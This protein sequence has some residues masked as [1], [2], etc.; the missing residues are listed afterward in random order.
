MREFRSLRMAGGPRRRAAHSPSQSRR[1][2][3]RRRTRSSGRA[4]GGIRRA[5][6]R[7]AAVG[8]A[9][10]GRSS[11]GEGDGRW[12]SA[13]KAH[14]AHATTHGARARG[15][16]PT[17]ASRRPARAAS[18]FSREKEDWSCDS[19]TVKGS[20][21][22]SNSSNIRQH[23]TP[24]SSSRRRRSTPPWRPPN[25]SARPA[26][27]LVTCGENMTRGGVRDTHKNGPHAKQHWIRE[28]CVRLGCATSA[29]DLC[30]RLVCE[31][32]VYVR[33]VC[34]RLARGLFNQRWITQRPSSNRPD[35]LLARCHRRG[36]ALAHR[37]LNT[38]ATVQK[39]ADSRVRTE[40]AQCATTHCEHT[41]DARVTNGQTIRLV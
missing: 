38:H 36:R 39:Q 7:R 28:T 19:N 35:Q 9:A 10:V 14:G 16:S 37:G 8:R 32:L 12:R 11:M 15:R 21:T 29:C 33:L 18:E 4:A 22:Y 27:L 13:A 1:R 17:R 34:V 2:G 40:K 41:P 5:W 6:C 23:P 26:A 25:P 20:S 31:R 3:Q 30:V 24:A